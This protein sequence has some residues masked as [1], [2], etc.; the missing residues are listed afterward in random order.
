MCVDG[1]AESARGRGCSCLCGDGAGARAR[2]SLVRGG[3]LCCVLV[4][5]SERGR[6][7]GGDGEVSGCGNGNGNKRGSESESGNSWLCGLR[8]LVAVSEKV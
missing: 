8:A 7:C 4:W 3:G 5:V 6:L 2:A 1:E